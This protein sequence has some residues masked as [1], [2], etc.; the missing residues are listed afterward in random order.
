[1]RAL[2]ISVF[3]F[4]LISDSFAQCREADS[5]IKIFRGKYTTENKNDLSS[6]TTFLNCSH[7]VCRSYLGVNDLYNALKFNIIERQ[8]Y[9]KIKLYS[10]DNVFLDRALYNIMYQR[11]LIY[12]RKE[13][14]NDALD[15]AFTLL[16]HYEGAGQPERCAIIEDEIGYIYYLFRNYKKSLEFYQKSSELIK[17]TN[18]AF[19]IGNSYNNLYGVYAAM[20]DKTTAIKYCFS[21]LAC[22]KKINHKEGMRAAYGNLATYYENINIDKALDYMLQSQALKPANTDIVNPGLDENVL[23]NLYLKKASLEKNAEKKKE[24]LEQS[25]ICYSKAQRIA[26]ALVNKNVMKDCLN[27]FANLESEKGNFDKAYRYVRLYNVYKDSLI[28]HE[29][30]AAS[31]NSLL[32]YE[33]DKKEREQQMLVEKKEAVKQKE[34]EKQ[35]ILKNFFILGF[36]VV[37]V[38]AVFVFRGLKAKQKAHRIISKQ[39]AEVE[40]Q[41]QII[42]TKQSQL[43]HSIN[44]AHRIQDNLLK[45]EA[46]LQSILPES[47]IIFKPRDIV[48]GD[49]YWFT[50]TESG[51]TI[52]ILA[53][54]TGHGVPGALLSMIGITAINEIVSHQK[55]YEPGEIMR[56]ISADVHD[57]FSKDKSVTQMDGMDFSVCKI[58]PA[59]KKVYFAGVNQGFYFFTQT[60][61]LTK[62]EAQINSINGIFD[63]K[64]N[65]KIDPRE[66][67]LKEDSFFYMLTDGIIDQLGEKSG[68][69][70]LSKRFE[71][72]LISTEKNVTVQKN[73]ITKALADWQGDYRQ[74][75]DISVIGFKI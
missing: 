16:K 17:A 10:N 8:F 60:G 34:F 41:K 40:N 28:G 57:A 46:D 19:K 35:K 39:K 65:E 67:D 58:S 33:F 36:M 11:I 53:D 31:V 56:R 48:S 54:C 61:G 49:F 14:Y 47:F 74:I 64:P 71:E 15:L 4:L 9:D 59:K 1:L 45:S 29:N 23:G 37:S 42:E 63:I 3:T 22:F 70:Y 30:T 69:K 13:G 43:L 32:K 72:S 5:L 24:F 51:D 27:G 68:K 66:V 2:I 62:I 21:A 6:D 50:K 20:G 26:R 55:V 18:D 7:S 12:E 25:E 75:D 52:I 38:L 44:Y 73:N